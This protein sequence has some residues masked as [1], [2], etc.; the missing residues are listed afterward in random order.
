MWRNNNLEGKRQLD[1]IRASQEN[2]HSRFPE[3][4]AR[5]LVKSPA[6]S[7]GYF[8]H[9]VVKYSFVDSTG[10]GARRWRIWNRR[11]H[12]LRDAHNPGRGEAH[13]LMCTSYTTVWYVC[14]RM[15]C[16]R[17][18]RISTTPK[19]YKLGSR[20]DNTVNLTVYVLT[21]IQWRTGRTWTPDPS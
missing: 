15:T 16:L 4:V 21:L 18:P 5:I 1:F 9:S 8:L 14:L 3:N 10:V 19:C 20:S 7:M 17:G 11:T 13:R 2:E 12:R 6:P